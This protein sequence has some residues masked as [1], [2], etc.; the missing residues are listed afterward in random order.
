MEILRNIFFFLISTTSGMLFMHNGHAAVSFGERSITEVL[1]YAS[2]STSCYLVVDGAASGPVSCQKTS[3]RWDATTT[4]GQ[5]ILS[6]LLASHARGAN[7]FLE[8]ED[9]CLG[10][11]P[12][13]RSVKQIE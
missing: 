6:L 8:A 2:A 5:N 1:C 12:Q 13:I 7:I 11:F 10:G 3:L 9:T 4:L